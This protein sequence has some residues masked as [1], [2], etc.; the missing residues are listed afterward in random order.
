MIYAID[1]WI[2]CISFTVSY[3]GQSQMSNAQFILRDSWLWNVMNGIIKHFNGYETQADL[4]TYE[5][6]EMT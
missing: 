1:F 4:E 5:P 2:C 3:F 6:R